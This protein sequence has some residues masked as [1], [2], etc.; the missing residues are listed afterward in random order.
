MT[1]IMECTEKI[2]KLCYKCV[3]YSQEGRENRIMIRREQKMQEIQTEILEIKIK[4]IPDA[5]NSRLDTAR[6]KLS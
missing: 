6:E 5:I 4:Y 3:P 2:L 1:E